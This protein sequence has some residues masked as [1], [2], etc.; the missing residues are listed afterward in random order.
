GHPARQAR[1]QP[2]P[3]RLGRR[4]RHL[5]VRRPGGGPDRD[6]AHPAPL[7]LRERPAGPAR[8]LDHG[9]P[10]ARRL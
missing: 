4:L 2:R 1:R 5:V 7:R 6:P 8:L 3:L 9:L 10:G